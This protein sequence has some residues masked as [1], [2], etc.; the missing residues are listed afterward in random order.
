MAIPAQEFEEAR[1][2]AAAERE[3]LEQR[4]KALE[5]AKEELEKAKADHEDATR[6][7]TQ[8]QERLEQRIEELEHAKTAQE[9]ATRTIIR[10]AVSTLGSR[11]NEFVTLGGTL[12]VLGGWREDFS[13]P[14]ENV[15]AL[16][17]AEL[18][19]EVQVNDW[20][21]GSMIIEWDDGTDVLFPTTAGFQSGVERVNIDTASITIGDPQRFPPFGTFGRIIVP[22]GISTGDP[23]ADVL[24][25]DDPLTIEVFETRRA[26]ILLGVGFPT[27]ALTPATPPVTPPPVKPLVISPFISALSKRLGYAPPPTRPPA[28]TPITPTPAPPP[29]NAAVYMYSGDTFAVTDKG[30]NPGEHFGAT[31][32]F[33][34]RGNCGRP[35]HQLGGDK[36]QRWWEIACPWSIDVDVDFNNSIFESRFLSF[37]YRDF[38]GQI[39]FVPGMA[40][41]VKA[42]LGPV[43]VIGEWN[44]AIGNA[45]LVD[46][47]GTFVSIRPSAWQ[48][49]LNY[50]FDWN[51]WVE[52]IGL[53][54]NY[55]ALGYSESHD[56]AG[57]TQSINGE[58]ERVGFVPKR[59]F[60]VSAGEWVLDG[61][62]I[63]VEYSHVVDYAKDKGGTGNSANGVFTVL[64]LV[65]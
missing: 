52:A 16:N 65:W 19:F 15:L 1:G 9:D 37:E 7:I 54:G 30:L 43:S 49:S 17:T 2:A 27:P 60:L 55:L 4:L 25:I 48:V 53:Q 63:A 35:Y 40:A 23:V 57:V 34:T 33:R 32:G 47:T 39:G 20:T 29:F 61:V 45:T 51:P 24:T 8:E 26:A 62:R 59:R 50:Q 64:T 21:L 12:E 13:G 11:I 5:K 56:L 31:A 3:R 46:D 22:F 18:D 44:G 14:S 42:T 10:D 28:L 38:L 6:S 36:R 58:A 41:H